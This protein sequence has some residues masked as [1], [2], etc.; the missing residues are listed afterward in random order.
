MRRPARHPAIRN[1][2]PCGCLVPCLTR[3]YDTSQMKTLLLCLCMLLVGSDLLGGQPGRVLPQ[4]TSV[5]FAQQGCPSNAQSRPLDR[6]PIAPNDYI[7]FRVIA[8]FSPMG[9]YRIRAYGDGRVEREMAGCLVHPHGSAIRV[10]PDTAQA[11]LIQARDGGFRQL[12]S[13]YTFVPQPGLY[14]D[15]DE[16]ALTLSLHGQEKSVLNSLGRPP[17]LYHELADAIKKI[18]P[19]DKF[20][21]E[22]DGSS[23]K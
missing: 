23:T 17:L 3:L 21:A 19:M 2:H 18:S 8:A 16:T 22:C 1:H 7:E 10:A 9:P 12:C 15:G 6:A 14:M 5:E 13:E 20:K 4:R 11:V